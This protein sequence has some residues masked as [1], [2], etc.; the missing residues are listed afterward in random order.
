M[1]DDEFTPRRFAR[2]IDRLIEAL[3]P[4]LSE[5]MVARFGFDRG[6][7]RDLREV[8]EHLGWSMERV[9]LRDGELNEALQ[10]AKN[11]RG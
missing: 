9:R 1:P 11:D 4:E 10:A 5:F 6:Q 8:A 2:D 7:P 3:P